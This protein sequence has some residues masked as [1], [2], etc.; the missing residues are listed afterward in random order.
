MH[1]LESEDKQRL[2]DWIRQ[3]REALDAIAR[4]FAYRGAN[5]ILEYAA[6]Y[7][8]VENRI[9]H[10]IADQIEQRVLPKLIGLDLHQAGSANALSSI[11]RVLDEIDDDKLKEQL[12]KSRREDYFQWTG[13][14]RTAV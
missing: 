5:A 13:L 7:P 14:D 9:E 3:I 11:A 8:E 12:E 1:D 4:P 10:A 6:N 2:L